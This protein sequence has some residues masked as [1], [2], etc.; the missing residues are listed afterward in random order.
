M[1]FS[2]LIGQAR[3]RGTMTPGSDADVRAAYAARAAEYVSVIGS[4]ELN[5]ERDRE[6]I[7]RWGRARSGLVIDAGCGPGH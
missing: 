3:Y 1:P 2:R 4:V 5:D 7:A 6:L